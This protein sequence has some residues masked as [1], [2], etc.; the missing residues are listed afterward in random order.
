MT[1]NLWWSMFRK[2]P[3]PCLRSH[4]RGIYSTFRQEVRYGDPTW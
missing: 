4:C 3:A 2:I 1:S